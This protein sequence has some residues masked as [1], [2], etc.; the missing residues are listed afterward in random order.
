[1]EIMSA[2]EVVKVTSLSYNRIIQPDSILAHADTILTC[3][4]RKP[5]FSKLTDLPNGR[6]FKVIWIMDCIPR[7]F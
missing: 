7:L 4:V 6:R 1:M 3:S 2:G 5:T